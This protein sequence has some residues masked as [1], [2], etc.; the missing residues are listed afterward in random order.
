MMDKKLMN[1]NHISD[2][3]I[4][5]LVTVRWLMR[6]RV[7]ME[8]DESVYWISANS[9]K[10]AFVEAEI[11]GA[12]YA[13]SG[14]QAFSEQLEY[15]GVSEIMPVYEMPRNG[16]QLGWKRLRVD[17]LECERDRLLCYEDLV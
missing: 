15:M 9:S 16:A 11:L 3:P 1:L 12:R 4:A 10:E 14:N 6:A 13:K 8:I 7:P 17:D 5:Y 2:K